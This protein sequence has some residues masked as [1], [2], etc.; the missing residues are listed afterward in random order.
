VDDVAIEFRTTTR[1]RRTGSR[2][3]KRRALAENLTT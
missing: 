3:A 1:W 2:G